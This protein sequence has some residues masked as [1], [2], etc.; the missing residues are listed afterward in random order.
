MSQE[1]VLGLDIGSES[2]GWSL[3]R[4][5][6]GLAGG[7]QDCGTHAFEA[8]VSGTSI[9]LEKGADES[10]GVERR[11]A[12]QARRQF[13][14]RAR[15]ARKVF[16]ILQRAGFLPDGHSAAPAEID[17]IIKALDAQ[18]RDP[19]YRI[20]DP[21]C[22]AGDHRAAQVLPYRLRALAIGSQPLPAF[23][24]GRALYS[25]AQ[26]RGFR[27]SRRD[28]AGST[29]GG[30]AKQ[31]PSKE[32]KEKA[33][34]LE[35][36]KAEIQSLRDAISAS[37][38][39]TLGAFLAARD[40]DREPIRRLHT[41]RAMFTEEFDEIV[42]AQGS[43][44]PALLGIRDVLR[45]AMFF[46]R[47][48]RSQSHLIG[49]CSLYPNRRRARLCIPPAQ[50][51]RIR[52]KL[53]D[54][55]V[56]AP[57]GITERPLSVDERESI[58]AV[59]DRDG[60]TKLTK[61]KKLLK[62]STKEKLNFAFADEEEKSLPGNRTGVRLRGIFGDRWDTLSDDERRA[63][64]HDWLSI[65]DE[66]QLQARAIE[67]WCLPEDAA[68]RF[69]HELRLEDGHAGLSE[70]AISEL[71]VPL[72]DG[73][74]YMTAVR[75]A[76]GEPEKT[77]PLDLLPP[78]LHT[79]V[80]RRLRNPAVQRALTELRK[81]VNAVIRR[82]GRPDRIRIELA[83]E[84]RTPRAQRAKQYKDNFARE[85]LR[86]AAKERILRECGIQQPR[87]D[88]I[89]RALLHEECQGV[90]PYTGESIDFA[91][92]FGRSSTIDVE[93][94]IPFSVSLDNSFANKTLC[95]RAENLR[96]GRRAPRAVYSHDEQRWHAI[97]QRVKRFRSDHAH[98]KLL[99]FQM[100]DE[101]IRERYGENFSEGQLQATR[102]SNR[103]ALEYLGLLYGGV[104]D[105]DGVRRVQPAPAGVTV[106][107]RREL[108]LEALWEEFA[109]LLPGGQQSLSDTPP[110]KR[111]RLTHL[112]HAVDALC[113][114]MATPAMIKRLSDAA[115]RAAEAHRRH[116]AQLPE[117][118]PGF[119]DDVRQRISAVIVSRRPNRRV[120]GSLHD[121]SNYSRPFIQINEKGKPA[122]VHRIRKPV[123]ALT[124]SSIED[125]VDPHIRRIVI[126]KVREVGDPKKLEGDWPMLP[127][128]D[129]RL[130]PIKRVRLHMSVKPRKIGRSGHERYVATGD[131]HHAVIY[132]DRYGR[133]QDEVV[134]RF[135]AV[136]RLNASPREPVV[137][138]DR[139]PDEQFIMWLV[140]GDY[141]RMDDAQGA[142]RVHRLLSISAGDYEFCEHLDARTTNDRKAARARIR[143]SPEKL[144]ERNAEKVTVTH[145]G[146]VEPARD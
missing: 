87:A 77:R 3:C 64:I 7:L 8:G 106:H 25:L 48:L 46:Q 9:D 137:R 31:K 115:S 19:A 63:I 28:A 139:G 44:H 78:V 39:K 105:A 116:F 70:R 104:I 55:R 140:P 110:H 68:R 67:H 14:R 51:F 49:R 130:I 108:G 100:T 84:L 20:G 53:N 128:R 40:P 80:G 123:T 101:D 131:N 29:D 62:L 6:D 98:A 79:D 66:D 60:D 142:R 54:L 71:L 136:R 35:G 21:L 103:L 4:V 107:L 65:Q 2:I 118:W 47:P 45:D 16:G 75:A 13:D 33:K 85:K 111:K 17:A 43:H 122:E 124:P 109:R 125:I 12:R 15:R 30:D 119:V 86:N 120:R 113:V 146:E 38:L 129:G 141:V 22:P 99:R 132:A 50:E 27:S 88:D 96:K 126:D 134:S 56:L 102:F 73:V 72:R 52:Q 57:D 144:R 95:I 135:D 59:L 34:E 74:P 97:L 117:P 37:G 69:A 26:R 112:H 143:A 82:H 42:K 76:F 121:G 83:R 94:I 114:T 11:L 92:L 127:T 61:V 138:R 89:E 23:E 36:M 91:S 41:D 5:A 10:R 93:H 18:L 81:V 32:Q 24:L 133:W 145:L 58:Y 1:I 90:C